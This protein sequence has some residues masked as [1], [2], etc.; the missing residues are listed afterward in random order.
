MKLNAL[1]SAAMAAL[2]VPIGAIAAGPGPAAPAATQF[3]FGALRVTS[4]ADGVYVLPN[5]GKIFGADVGPSAVAE[6]LKAAQAPTDQITLPVD[7]LLVRDGAHLVLI[8]TG[9]GPKVGGVLLDSLKLADATAAQV[10]D[11]LITHPHPDHIGGLLTKAGES[12]FPHAKIWFSSVDWAA[13][14]TQ[15]GMAEVIKVIGPQVEPF[16][17][18]AKVTPSI[19]S[20][21]LKGHTPGHVGYEVVSGGSRLLDIGDAA[22]SAILSLQK[23]EWTMGFDS[24]PQVAKDNRRATLARLAASH[25]TIFAP[26]FP[27]PG[28][29]TVVTAADAFAWHPAVEADGARRK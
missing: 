1:L 7:A 6:V 3:T 17:A 5:D 2:L 13:L 18:G 24:E 12:A 4:L 10:T 15:S 19:T 21:P 16:D 25:E 22:H 8:D 27:Y 26:H 11:V 14:Q 20:V 23:P 29:G 9:L 28:I